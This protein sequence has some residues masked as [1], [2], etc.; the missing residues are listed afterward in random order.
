MEGEN[1]VEQVFDQKIHLRG[2][3]HRILAH[4]YTVFFV[5]FLFSVYLDFVFQIKIF[6]SSIMVPVGF[7]FLILATIV[8]FWA[9]KA[10][11]DFKKLRNQDVRTEHFL[12]GP[13]Q[14]TRT[15]T[16]FGLFFLFLGFG[17]MA[18]AFFVVL[19]TVISFL[20]TKFYFLDKQESMLAEKYGSHYTEYKKQV[21]F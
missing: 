10:G 2:K 7:L 9:Q 18:N 6:K 12:R 20:I 1:K 5:L 11:R 4:S 21:K 8:I 14:Y 13:Y 3:V 16:H 19:F 17:I 15:P